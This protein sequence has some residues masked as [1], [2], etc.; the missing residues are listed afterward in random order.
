M[1]ITSR[2]PLG[3]KNHLPRQ[4]II[5]I[6]TPPKISIRALVSLT[7]TRGPPA[8]YH[9]LMTWDRK[10]VLPALSRGRCKV[11][12]LLFCAYIIRVTG[13]REWMT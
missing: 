4:F 1:K 5:R 7:K 9:E 10:A 13:E 8:T 11:F 12:L 3:T 2:A 6:R